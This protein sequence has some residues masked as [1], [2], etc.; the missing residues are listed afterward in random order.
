ME[1]NRTLRQNSFI[2]AAAADIIINAASI[3]P[4]V[5]ELMLDEQIGS[6]LHIEECHSE[7]IYWAPLMSKQ[8]LM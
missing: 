1:V 5:P 6:A 7:V 4:D 8:Q 2:V 3:S